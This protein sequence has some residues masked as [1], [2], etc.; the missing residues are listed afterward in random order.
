CARGK[1]IVHLDADCS[2]YPDAIENAVIPFYLDDRI[3]AVGGNL[4]VRNDMDSLCT[5]LQAIE[6]LI[7]ITIGR[8]VSSSLGILRIVSGAFGVFRADLLQRIKGW[9][10][11][12]G[13]DGDLTLKIRKLGYKVHFEPRAT[14]LTTVPDGFGKL[15]RQRVRWSRSLI[16][17]RLRKHVDLMVPNRNF[18]LMNFA[19]VA[20]NIMY[21]L[22]LNV[23]WFVY[24]AYI[25]IN[26]SQVLGYIIITGFAL[27]TLSKVLEFIVVLLMS[28]H[29]RTKLKYI[30]YL[31]AMVL[32]TGY[33]IRVIRTWAYI[34]EFFFR[35][36]YNDPWNPYK[37]SSEALK[38][39]KSIT[40]L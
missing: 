16:R 10:V 17:F 23:M 38:M 7:F 5:T 9:D 22:V 8:S 4:E 31:P 35:S 20:E 27:Y 28:P 21:D 6:Y 26:F 37:T 25:I 13:L 2:F 32:Y 34:K 11:G 19:S 14:A 18:N 30:P 39:E 15:A 3:G 1:F 33:Y 36:S 12:P 29:W 24:I 40:K